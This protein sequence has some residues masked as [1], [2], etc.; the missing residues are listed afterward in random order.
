MNRP[1]S[2]SV[3]ISLVLGFLVAFATIW[4]LLVRNYKSFENSDSAIS[5]LTRL[6]TG[7]VRETYRNKPEVADPADPDL[8]DPA[9]KGP[10]NEEIP[11]EPAP[12]AAA[13]QES[14]PQALP[15]IEVASNE[16]SPVKPLP[17]RTEP[18]AKTERS[19]TQT[20]PLPDASSPAGQ[21]SARSAPLTVNDSAPQIS[22]AEKPARLKTPGLK[23]SEVNSNNAR[24]ETFYTDDARTKHLPDKNSAVTSNAGEITDEETS[25]TADQLQQTFAGLEGEIP[26]LQEKLAGLNRKKPTPKETPK[27][28][29]TPAKR[30]A[31][32]PVR[33]FSLE[34]KQPSDPVDERD[35]NPDWFR[36]VNQL[37]EKSREIPL[38]QRSR[39]Y[40][41]IERLT[42]ERVRWVLD[43]HPEWV[44][45]HRKRDHQGEVVYEDLF[46]IEYENELAAQFRQKK[47]YFREL[48]D[49]GVRVHSHK[50]TK[51]CE[52]S[53]EYIKQLREEDR[54][55]S[56][57]RRKT[58]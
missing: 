2:R 39:I 29:D 5:S 46:W 37:R 11:A 54:K 22:T 30:P 52:A 48:N 56:E 26:G 34:V 25:A 58:P 20:S 32:A 43:Y 42:T 10:G 3:R 21:V 27:Q 51:H 6:F 15:L 49:L 36:H 44:L 17:S 9:P 35:R 31:N 24:S 55:E 47:I 45:K 28:S 13:Q 19:Q 50:Y 38:K 18:P 7:D 23:P 16:P 33:L 57:R 1:D 53:I 14:A 8:A 4:V 41:E 40:D 12:D